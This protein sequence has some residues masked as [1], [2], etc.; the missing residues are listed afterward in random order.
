[1]EKNILIDIMYRKCRIPTLVKLF[2]FGFTFCKASNDTRTYSDKSECGLQL[3]DCEYTT[4]TLH[5]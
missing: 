1:M 2:C 3:I 4:L 5:R